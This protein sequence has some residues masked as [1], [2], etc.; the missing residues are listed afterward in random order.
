MLKNRRMI[1]LI[2]CICVITVFLLS[3]CFVAAYSHHDCIGKD[4][5]ICVQLQFAKNIIEQFN[6]CQAVLLVI[7]IVFM[8]GILFRILFCSMDDTCYS[9]IQ[10]KVRLNN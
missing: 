6:N 10:Q 8:I 5:P 4:C 3:V 9:L 2:L 1:A 7:H